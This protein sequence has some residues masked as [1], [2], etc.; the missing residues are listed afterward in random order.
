MTGLMQVE[1]VLVFAVCDGSV[2]A[3]A[4]MLGWKF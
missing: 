2:L 3:A 4:A 1:L